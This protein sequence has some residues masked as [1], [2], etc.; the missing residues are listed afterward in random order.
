MTSRLELFAPQ[1]MLLLPLEEDQVTL[2]RA[3]TNTVSLE[4]DR[5]V[6]E[7]HAVLVQYPGGWCIRDLSSRNGT[8]VNG[9]RIFGERPLRSG[10]EVRLGSTRIVYLDADPGVELSRTESAETPPPLTARERDVLAALCAVFWRDVFSAPAS[11]REMADALVVTEAAVKQHLLRL[12]EKFGIEDRGERGRVRLANEALR[13]GAIT[14]G[15][16]RSGRRR[17]TR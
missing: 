3:R 9:E 7:A 13:R 17:K 8:F 14:I 11:V 6:S 15:D 1:G 4:W 10:D 2:G 12:Y 5:S 16:L